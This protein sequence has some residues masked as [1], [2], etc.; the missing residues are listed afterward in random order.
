MGGNTYVA[1]ELL[2][3]WGKRHN[4]CIP[5]AISLTWGPPFF[6]RLCKLRQTTRP[7]VTRYVS[8]EE[9]IAGPVFLFRPKLAMRFL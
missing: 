8:Y 1:K 6:P 5:K 7:C 3:T 9:L 2:A 4:S